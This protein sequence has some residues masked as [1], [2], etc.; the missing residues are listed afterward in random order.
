MNKEGFR[1]LITLGFLIASP[2]SRTPVY[3]GSVSILTMIS[4]LTFGALAKRGSFLIESQGTLKREQ[5]K[6]AIV[7][8]AVIVIELS[9]VS[10]LKG[11][12]DISTSNVDTKLSELLLYENLLLEIQLSMNYLKYTLSLWCLYTGNT[13]RIMFPWYSF[14]KYISFILGTIVTIILILSL[15]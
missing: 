11:Q 15:L 3:F 10:N 1:L 9:I 8:M 2:F 13:F 14:A 4:I 6:I 12:Y 5:A 7:Y